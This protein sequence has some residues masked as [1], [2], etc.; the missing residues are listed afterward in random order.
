MKVTRPH[1]LVGKGVASLLA[2]WLMMI[3]A[4]A[5]T[6]G[7]YDLTWSTIDGG[8][9]SP[10]SPGSDASTGGDY[11]LS[12]TIGQPD[13]RTKFMTG[14]GYTLLGGFWVIPECPAVPADYDGDCDVDHADFAHFE[15]CFS[16]PTVLYAGDCSDASFDSD[17]DVDHKD[18]GI[19][20]RCYSGENYP[21]DP[22]CAD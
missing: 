3:P 12:G 5:Q 10:G 11:A 19:F 2:V 18:F 15:A 21:A 4:F 8:G 9:A 14:G 22:D 16:G 13:A 17:N 6:G 20:Q 1:S 7:G